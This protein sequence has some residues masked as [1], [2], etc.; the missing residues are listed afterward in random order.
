MSS[1]MDIR[2]FLGLDDYYRRFVEGFS[3]IVLPY[4]KLTQKG[5]PFRWLDEYE[6]IFQKLKTAL[7]TSPVQVL[8]S[9][10]GSYTVYCD[11]SQIGI[12]CVFM[13]EGRVIAYSLRQLI[14]IDCFL[15]TVYDLELAAIV[16]AL[17]IWRHYLYSVSCKDRLRTV[18]SRQKSYTNQKVCDVSFIVG[19]KVLLKVSPIKGV[20][21]FEKKGKLSLRYIG[22]FEVLQ[23]IG[24]VAYKHALPPSLSSVHPVFHVSMLQKYVG[25]LSHVLDFSTVHLEGSLTCDVELVAI[26]GRQVRKLRSKDIALVKVLWR[27]Q[28]VDEATWETK[29]EIQSRYPHLF[30]TLCMFLD[31]FEDERL[32]KRGR[33]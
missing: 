2:S 7:T 29:R 12:A 16:R 11:T 14:W 18:Q 6:E 20:M 23:R 24:N 4:T 27:A 8:P 31:T 28:L 3:S 26:L 13:W 33:M 32:F 9:A 22:P 30:E 15:Y 17:K 1:A 19:E 21:R 5:A 10:L 25:N